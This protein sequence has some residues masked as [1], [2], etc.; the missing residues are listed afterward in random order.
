[1]KVKR[2]LAEPS[3]DAVVEVTPR[4]W[5]ASGFNADLILEKRGSTR[6]FSVL[7]GGRWILFIIK[8]EEK[9]DETRHT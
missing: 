9:K 7:V 6:T 2:F 3:Y 5:E 1:V 4:E 8:K